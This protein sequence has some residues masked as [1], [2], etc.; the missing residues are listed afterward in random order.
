[1]HQ[2]ALLNLFYRWLVDQSSWALPILYLL[3]RDLRLLAEEVSSSSYMLLNP[4]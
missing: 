1:M 4:S 2:N 3:L